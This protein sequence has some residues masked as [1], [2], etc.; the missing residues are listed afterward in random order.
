V[1]L[2]AACEVISLTKRELLLIRSF[3]FLSGLPLAV[4][5]LHSFDAKEQKQE[6]IPQMLARFAGSQYSH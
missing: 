1:T 3:P 6:N 4:A 2:S 5:G